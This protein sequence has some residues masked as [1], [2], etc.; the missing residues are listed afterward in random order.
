MG[1]HRL[2]P[3]RAGTPVRVGLLGASAAVALGTAVVASGLLPGGDPFVLG[4]DRSPAQ[5]AS[6]GSPGP[7]A[8]GGT[9]TG[10]SPTTP[11]TAP[12]SPAPPSARPSTA[13][14]AP[15]KAA[16]APPPPPSPTVPAPRSPETTPE[17]TV[18][19]PGPAKKPS[20]KPTPD[21]RPVTPPQPGRETGSNPGSGTEAEAQVLA[22]VNEERSKVGCSPVR[23]DSALATLAGDFSADMAQRGFFS[24]TDPDGRTP[25]D[26]A[27]R[28]GIT[29]MGG[30]N[31]ARGQADPGAVMNAWMKSEG[32]RA[33][34]LNCEYKKL[35]VGV[36]LGSG[37]PWWTQN[38][39]F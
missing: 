6:S 23:F 3:R 25:W 20:A 22:L 27:K 29:Y 10:T 36:H 9:E 32:H 35:G 26:R 31:I 39:G 28:A 2:N 12:P 21:R 17:R 1:R 4:S 30:E 5:R 8:P 33:N 38:F 34:I 15:A 11:S 18:T 14:T 13:P 37:G 7:S 19:P 16:P 24:H